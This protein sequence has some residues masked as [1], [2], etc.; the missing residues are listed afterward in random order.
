MC[1]AHILASHGIVD[2]D[3]LIFIEEGNEI[4][5]EIHTLLPWYVAILTRL[6]CIM[7]PFCGNV[8]SSAAAS[9]WLA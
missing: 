9:R 3:G 2:I 6:W 1:P 4:V 5:V 7:D 8:N